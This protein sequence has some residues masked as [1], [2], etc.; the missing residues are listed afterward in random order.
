MNCF[1]VIIITWMVHSSKMLMKFCMVSSVTFTFGED[2]EGHIDAGKGSIS[3]LTTDLVEANPKAHDQLLD[4][5]LILTHFGGEPFQGGEA[6]GRVGP[7]L[8]L[9]TF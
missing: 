2:G 3:D 5:P 8:V 7:L 1:A 4:D 6:L 9:P